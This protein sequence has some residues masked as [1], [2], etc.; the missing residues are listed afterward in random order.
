MI[1]KVDLPDGFLPPRM[2]DRPQY[3]GVQGLYSRAHG[4]HH[5]LWSSYQKAKLETEAKRI[6]IAASR[7]R[8]GEY[9]TV[10]DLVLEYR[11]RWNI[12]DYGL[13]EMFWDCARVQG[14]ELRA[15]LEAA[16]RG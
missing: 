8:K 4:K 15:W 16:E 7:A 13:C 9:R 6:R 5:P 2:K 1:R 10:E 3:W 14:T 12:S 11:T